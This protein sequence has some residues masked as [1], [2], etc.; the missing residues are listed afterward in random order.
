MGQRAKISFVIQVWEPPRFLRHLNRALSESSRTEVKHIVGST[1]TSV[2]TYVA[3]V[4]FVRYQR[5]DDPRLAGSIATLL[6]GGLYCGQ[7]SVS[8]F[9]AYSPGVSGSINGNLCLGGQLRAG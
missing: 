5:Q 9:R 4:V 8:R 7:L 3:V 1:I 2:R 6:R